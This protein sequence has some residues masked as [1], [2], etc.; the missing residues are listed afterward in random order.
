MRSSLTFL[1]VS[2]IA[3]LTLGCEPKEAKKEDASAKAP[4]EDTTK[5]EA[6]EDTKTEDPG[7]AAKADTEKAEEAKPTTLAEV[8][9]PAP[10]FTLTDASGKEHKLSD[11]KG[12]HV[13]LEWT[14]PTCPYVVRHYDAK[15]MTTTADASG[16]DV[17]WLAVD[18]SNFVKA[19]EAKAWKEKHGIAYPIL[20]DAKGDVGRTYAA[21]TTPHMYVVDKEGVLRYSG[22]IDDDPRGEKKGEATNYVTTTLEA[23]K[24]GK[25]VETSQTKPYGCSVKYGS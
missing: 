7:A 1:F 9:K 6:A 5:K 24:A 18:S 12:K 22:A 4:V 16:D 20:L 14:N 8:G 15:T 10:D 21:K 19:E 17:V 2:I 25:E 11:Y 13:V 3:G 23:L